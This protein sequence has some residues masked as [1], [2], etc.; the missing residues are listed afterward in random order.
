MVAHLFNRQRDEGQAADMMTRSA[1]LFGVSPDNFAPFFFAGS[2]QGIEVLLAAHRKSADAI[3]AEWGNLPVGLTIAMQDMQ[4]VEGGQAVRDA[5]RC[6]IQDIWLEAA[7]TDDFVG[8][9][10]YSR[11]RFGPDGPLGPEDGVELTQ[12][13]YEFWPEA[14]EATLHYANEIA[15]VP[16]MVTENG[17][18]TQDDTRRV[19]YYQRALRSV[20]NALDEGLD[21]RGYFA[22]SAFDNFEWL[23]GYGPKFGIIHVDRST[24]K[25]TIK[26]SARLLGEIAL[27][28]QLIT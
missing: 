2:P 4:A 17:I 7:R 10:T 9:Q 28:N 15:G 24:Q 18:G 6:D 14:L 20:A 27:A 16:L 3:R 1:K 21:I 23:M 25:R 19:A 12:M 22:W 11:Q 26:P 8:V 5:H 13:G